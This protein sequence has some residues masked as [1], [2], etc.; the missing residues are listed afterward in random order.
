MKLMQ[1]VLV[2]KVTS[3]KKLRELF[4]CKITK[5]KSYLNHAWTKLKFIYEAFFT[6]FVNSQIHLSKI[7]TIILSE[8]TSEGIVIRM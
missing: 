5:T 7:L 3:K 1:L 2:I 4:K 6:F 8:I